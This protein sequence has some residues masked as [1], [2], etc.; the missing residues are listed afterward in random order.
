[1]LL[2][3]RRFVQIIDLQMNIERQIDFEMES[4]SCDEEL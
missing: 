1:M 4:V 2:C 3:T